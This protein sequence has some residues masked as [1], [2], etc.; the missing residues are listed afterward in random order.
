MPAEG[1]GAIRSSMTMVR[2]ELPAMLLLV[3][4]KLAHWK[5]KQRN[6]AAVPSGAIKKIPSDVKPGKKDK[7]V[8]T[9]GKSKPKNAQGNGTNNAQIGTDVLDELSRNLTGIM[10]EHITD[11][12]LYQEWDWGEQWKRHDVGEDGKWAIPPGARVAGKLNDRTTLNRLFALK[13]HGPGIDGVWKVK[14]TDPHNRRKKYAIVESKASANKRAPKD[15]LKRANINNK[16][17]HNGRRIAD[18]LNPKLDDLL[19]PETYDDKAPVKKTKGRKGSGTM[20]TPGKG[21]QPKTSPPAN[22]NETQEAK[23]VNSDE[24]EHAIVQMSHIWIEKNIFGALK[25]APAIAAEIKA[26]GKK[27]YSRHLFFTPLHLDT[28]TEHSEARLLGDHEGVEKLHRNHKI[29]P[30]NIYDETAVKAAVNH[31]SRKLKIPLEL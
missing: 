11:Y 1:Q 24:M 10:G 25:D 17:G 26:K 18:K 12:F 3:T 9:S 20:T 7:K 8:A 14:T 6:N 22:K 31:K 15:P 19:E 4:L 27:V 5:T 29:P 30:Q 16:L 21:A 13:A 28:T 23:D 2:A